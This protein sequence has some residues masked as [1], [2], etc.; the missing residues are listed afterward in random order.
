MR[1]WRVPDESTHDV[2]ALGVWRRDALEEEVR[3]ANRADPTARRVGAP[4]HG[5]LTRY[6]RGCR[7]DMCRAAMREYQRERRARAS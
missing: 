7:C 6:N 5:T 1:D 3:L 2:R 4:E